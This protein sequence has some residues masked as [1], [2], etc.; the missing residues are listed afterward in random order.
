LYKENISFKFIIFIP[1]LQEDFSK[2]GSYLIS[3]LI[4][5]TIKVNRNLNGEWK[6]WKN[7]FVPINKTLDKE[8]KNPYNYSVWI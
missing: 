3:K 1:F 6:G 7:F 4:K 2:S 5:K 8:P